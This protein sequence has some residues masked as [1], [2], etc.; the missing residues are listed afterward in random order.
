[1]NID[2]TGQFRLQSVQ[3]T[4]DVDTPTVPEPGSLALAGAA[5]AG[6]VVA[7]RRNRKQ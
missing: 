7:S 1:M 5:L 3:I 6:L 4:V 2:A